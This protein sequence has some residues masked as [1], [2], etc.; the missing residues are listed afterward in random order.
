MLDDNSYKRHECADYIRYREE[1]FTYAFDDDAYESPPSS[2]GDD[3]ALRESIDEDSSSSKAGDTTKGPS[4]S[5]VDE[6][7]ISLSRLREDEASKN[8]SRSGETNATK[9]LLSSKEDDAT[10]PTSRS[11]ERLLSSGPRELALGAFAVSCFII[12]INISL[13]RQRCCTH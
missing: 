11:S 12:S 1:G 10:N 3:A 4:S 8:P 7:T 13:H 5:K 2:K 6:A 9:C